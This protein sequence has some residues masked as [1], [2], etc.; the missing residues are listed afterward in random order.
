MTGNFEV[1][2]RKPKPVELV[3]WDDVGSQVLLDALEP[4]SYYIL[5]VRKKVIYL[6]PVIVWD[7]V[8][9]AL[10]RR[11]TH[12]GIVIK[13]CR[14]K[15]VITLIDNNL[16]FHQ[17][18]SRFPAVRFIAIQNGVRF[19]TF[20]DEALPFGPSAKYESEYLCLGPSE[21]DSLKM[22]GIQFKQIKPIGSLRNALFAQSLR[23]STEGALTIK[24]Y[25]I[26]WIS[27]YRKINLESTSHIWEVESVTALQL[28]HSYLESHAE[29]R[30][31]VAMVCAKDHPD[32]DAEVIF[33]R[34]H[35]GNLADL[36]P[37][38]EDWMSSYHIT[39][40]SEVVVSSFSTLSLENL[41]R[42][43]KTLMCSSIYSE[44]FVDQLFSPDW[45]LRRLDHENFDEA[46]TKLLAMTRKDFLSRNSKSINY[47]VVPCHTDFILHLVR[48]VLE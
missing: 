43:R 40:K 24:Q 3:I 26:V 9:N 37:K 28:L 29:V 46:I 44:I 33:Y 36:I 45:T 42:G 22:F 34:E 27:Q 15:T 41:A 48:E 7:T 11:N 32:Y 16:R 10:T 5:N 19:Y 23:D 2:W 31:S 39:E 38:S 18:A 1:S 13:Y 14:P 20:P 8:I 47:V 21:I 35:L 30:A 6:H 4:P 12:Y 25:D 17:L